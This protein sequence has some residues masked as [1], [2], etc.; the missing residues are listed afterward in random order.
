MGRLP[1]T[2]GKRFLLAGVIAVL[3]LTLVSALGVWGMREA[4][5]GSAQINL[6][7]TA[8]RNHMESDMMHDALRADVLLAMREGRAG[9][10]AAQKDV[11]AATADHIKNF[12]D[13]VEA[14]KEIDLPP[15]ARAALDDIGPALTAYIAAAKEEVEK[16]FSDNYVAQEGFPEF[17]KKFEALEEKMGATSDAI[18]HSADVIKT[19][20]DANVHHLFI[21]LIIVIVI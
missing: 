3:A 6:I 21:M 1:L 15:E 7:S 5:N 17:M 16:S 19:G 12:E 4:A 9:N 8:V 14:N 20:I 11:D 2:I 18:Q 10:K 13:H